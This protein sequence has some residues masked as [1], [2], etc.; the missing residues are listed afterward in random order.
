MTNAGRQTP[1]F[2]SASHIV[3]GLLGCSG[4]VLAQ[5]GATPPPVAAG[6]TTL[7]AKP[8][9]GVGSKAPPFTIASWIKGEPVAAPTPGTVWVVEFFASWCVPCRKT[10]PRLSALQTKHT[11]E[12]LRIVAISSNEPRGEP[13]V[14]DFVA[15]NAARITY[16]V[17]WDAD[18]RT[19]DAWTGGSASAPIPLAFIVD[20]RGDVAWIGNPLFPAGEFE[21]TLE[22]VIAGTFD[23]DAAK[24]AAARHA[25]DRKAAQEILVKVDEAWQLGKQR[26]AMDLVD[27]AITL[28]PARWAPMGIDKFITLATRLND[29]DGAYAYARTLVDKTFHDNPALLA[30]LSGKILEHPGLTRRDADLALA[31]AA[32]AVELAPDDATA[33]DALARATFEKGDSAKAVELQ[34]RAITAAEDEPTKQALRKRLDRYST[35]K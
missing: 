2:R 22:S 30:A 1:P 5:P 35:P 3:L 25:A 23:M 6:S 12:R 27:R 33:L 13:D 31:A 8:E 32:R 18:G 15:A 16:A 14:R 28:D 4:V 20:Q 11:Q 10:I 19:A 34:N 17:A 29:T 7:G 26:E 21:R 24:A 9:I